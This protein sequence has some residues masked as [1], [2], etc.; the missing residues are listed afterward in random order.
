MTQAPVFG[1]RAIPL[2]LDLAAFLA[3]LEIPARTGRENKVNGPMHG[4]LRALLLQQLHHRLTDLPEAY[5]NRLVKID[6]RI[7]FTASWGEWSKKEIPFLSAIQI[8]L[9]FRNLIDANYVQVAHTADVYGRVSLSINYELLARDMQADQRFQALLPLLSGPETPD[10]RIRGLIPGSAPRSQDQPPDPGITESDQSEKTESVK[11]S[12]E[13]V[14]MDISIRSDQSLPTA[15]KTPGRGAADFDWSAESDENPG[16][17]FRITYDLLSAEGILEPSLSK[18]AKYRSAELIQSWI[19]I[20]EY[21]MRPYK[22]G[23]MQRKDWR[24]WLV[25]VLKKKQPAPEPKAATI[26]RDD[27]PEE[28]K[29]ALDKY[30][31]D[32]DGFDVERINAI[33]RKYGVAIPAKFDTPSKPNYTK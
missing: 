4:A 12:L 25:H 3:V 28:E 23:G 32:Y 21:C 33:R 9:E 24:A 19:A 17:V 22:Q 5:T 2:Y 31:Y 30:A 14:D 6:E 11:D 16:D 8:R 20:K 1:P 10:P 7:Y 13:S 26:S 27:V 29:F 15:E 18:A